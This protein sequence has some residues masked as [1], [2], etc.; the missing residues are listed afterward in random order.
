MNNTD[1]HKFNL[2]NMTFLA[3]AFLLALASALPSNGSTLVYGD[4][5]HEVVASDSHAH[6]AALGYKMGCDDQSSLHCGVKLTVGG[7]QLPLGFGPIGPSFA[8]RNSLMLLA[9]MIAQDTPPP[10]L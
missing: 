5:G 8:S 6:T 10:R 7:I 4:H 1:R 9:R 2:V 3:L